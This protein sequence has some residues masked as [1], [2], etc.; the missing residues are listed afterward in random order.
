M[1]I[2]SQISA[3][4]HLKTRHVA[5]GTSLTLLSVQVSLTTPELHDYTL[6]EHQ[7]ILQNGIH[8]TEDIL[9][10]IQLDPKNPQVDP[11]VHLNHYYIIKTP[12][13]HLIDPHLVPLHADMI[14]I[15][16]NVAYFDDVPLTPHHLFQAVRI[17]HRSVQFRP[18]D[19]PYFTTWSFRSSYPIYLDDSAEEVYLD[20]YF[21]FKKLSDALNNHPYLSFHLN[22]HQPY[23]TIAINKDMQQTIAQFLHAQPTTTVSFMHL[24]DFLFQKYVTPH[25][26]PCV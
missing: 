1:D 8:R 13:T 17:D 12:N 16:D 10:A 25:I 23:L 14:S 18:V 9:E 22:N 3:T 19:I 11:A 20:T 4:L 21:D 26:L 24:G 15:L 5:I 2:V 7:Y 6:T